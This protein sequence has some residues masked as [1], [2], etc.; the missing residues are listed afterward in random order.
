MQINITVPKI[1]LLLKNYNKDDLPLIR[2][3]S[4][5]ASFTL[6]NINELVTIF[7]IP[8]NSFN[9]IWFKII[10]YLFNYYFPQ[11]NANFEIETYAAC[12]FNQELGNWETFILQN[13][14]DQIDSSGLNLIVNI[15]KNQKIKSQKFIILVT[16]Q[17]EQTHSVKNE[18][19]CKE[20][21]EKSLETFLH[22]FIIQ[23]YSNSNVELIIKK[24]LLNSI[25]LITNA[26]SLKTESTNE[27][28]DQVDP[29]DN[30]LEF[31][32]SDS[33]YE[34][35]NSYL[36]KNMNNIEVKLENITDF[37]FE[38]KFN[39]YNP[40]LL[41]SNQYMSISNIKMKTLDIRL[42]ELP[43]RT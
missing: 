24:E 1:T 5:D 41:K 16:I 2:F 13:K 38:F 39:N 29:G 34:F 18:V 42:I 21:I 22:K 37:N 40:F 43:L 32:K 12:F 6:N 35:F 4:E 20:I 17:V 23:F 36:S 26:F 30:N 15:L 27:N 9:L 8:I 19:F 25:Y 31:F 28:K 3:I 7:Q 10:F 11:L 14:T 33:E